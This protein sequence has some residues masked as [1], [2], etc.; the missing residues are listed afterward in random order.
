[1]MRW[2]LTGQHS[3]WY[4]I[5]RKRPCEEI[6]AEHCRCRTGITF[7]AHPGSRPRLWW[8]YLRP[9]PRQRLGGIGTRA[10]RAAPTCATRMTT[11]S[12]RLGG[13]KGDHMTRGVPH[14]CGR[15]TDFESEASYL[16]RLGL[17]LPGERKRIP[18]VDFQ[19]VV[20]RIVDGYIGWSVLAFTDQALARRH[21]RRNGTAPRNWAPRRARSAP[22]ARACLAAVQAAAL[23]MSI[24]G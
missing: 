3:A 4:Y 18:R 17:L 2:L 20:I 9:E 13:A 14:L 19:P 11:A 15:S 12:L 6:W 1:M 24:G 8:W 7:G 16:K 10:P 22:A 23:A 21:H 5:F